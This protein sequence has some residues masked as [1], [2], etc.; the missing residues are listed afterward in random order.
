MKQFKIGLTGG[1][2]SGKSTVTKLLEKLGIVIIDADKISRAS[3]ASGGEAIEAIRV[4]FGDAMIDDTG[5]L[6]RAKM[7]ELVFQ[8]ADAR[9][10]LEA[11]VHPIIQAHMRIQA[12]QATS[13]YV[14]YD[15]PLLIESVER[16]RPQF[17]RICVVDC[18]E[19]TQI[20]RV[21]SRSQLTV[22]EIRR[23]IA[24][25][26]SRADRLVHAD[27]VIHNGVG[28]D[29]AELQRQV[30]QMHECWLELSEKG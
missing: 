7:R 11:I 28:V 25:Q 4:A 13:A 24:S 17:K 8:E 1:I 5:A 22:D 30:H 23:I 20:S 3:T 19:E 21:Q 26:A 27:D 14:V 12:E 9:Q 29:L 10:R 16:Y 2:G 15:I 18:D 6:D